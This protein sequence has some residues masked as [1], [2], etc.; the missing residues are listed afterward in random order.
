MRSREIDFTIPV[1]SRG[2][3]GKIILA[4]TPEIQYVLDMALSEA[5]RMVKAWTGNFYFFDES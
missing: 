2:P 4:R 1:V 5:L 3:A